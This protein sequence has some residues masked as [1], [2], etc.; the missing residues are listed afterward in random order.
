MYI[1]YAYVYIYTR[2]HLCVL[3]SRISYCWKRLEI[4][5]EKSI[6]KYETIHERQSM[7]RW[8]A[9]SK[10][11]IHRSDDGGKTERIRHKELLIFG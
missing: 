1:I 5:I 11:T 7:I 8:P 2:V 4:E 6:T 3:F 10:R 9:E